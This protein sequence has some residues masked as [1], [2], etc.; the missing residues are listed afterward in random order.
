MKKILFAAS[1]IAIA[2]GMASC[3]DYFLDLNPTD[4]QTEANFYKTPEEFEAAA[5]STYSFYGFGDVSE[6]VNGTKYTSSYYDML[7]V[8]SDILAGINP[9]AQGILAPSTNDTYWSLCYAKIRKCNVVI[10]KGEEYTGTGSINASLAVARFFRAYQ[11][12]WLLQRFGGVPVITKGLTSTS[13]E[14]YAP[15]NSRYEVAK[16]IF[17][18]LDY[19]IQ[20]LPDESAYDG[21]ISKQG[22][23]AFKARTLLFEATWEKYVGTTTDGDGTTSG[24][25]SDKPVGYPVITKGLT[26]TSEELY[27]PRNSRYEVAKQIFDD[28]DYAI[29]Y[30]PDESA[31]DGK[32]SKQG[33]QAF[34][35]RTLLFEATWE[36][37]VGTTTDGDGTTSG[38]G[39]DK[40]V[41]YPDIQSMLTEAA[42]LADAVMSSGKYQLWNAEGTIYEGIAY[43]YLFN[44][45]DENTNPM[46]FTK[47]KNHEFIL[48]IAYNHTSKRIG[49][50]I[51]KATGGDNNNTGAVTIKMVNMFPCVT[52]GLPYFYSKDYKGYN[53]MTDIYTCRDTRFTSCIKIPG[54]TYYWMGANGADKSLYLKANYVTTFDFPSGCS[55]YYPLVQNSGQT[56]FQNRKMCSERKD[57]KDT[58]EGY[59]YPVLR[60]A[61]VYLI[62]AEAKC[63]LGDG[64][65]SDSDLDKSINLL[66]DR[67]GSARISNASVAQ[68]NANYQA[69][70][71]KSGNLTML[72]LIRNERAVE[73]RNENL[74]PTDLLRWGIAEEALNADRSGIVVKNPD[75]ND[76]EFAGFG[77]EVAGKVEKIWDGVAIY[78]YE[79][80]DDGSQALIINSKSQFNMQRKHY[81]YPLPLAQIQLNPALL[82]NPGY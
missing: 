66:H 20:Y 67:G 9:V 63:E 18:D 8:N 13:E 5:N 6:T 65:I 71:G 34:K 50:N 46:G 58:D 41:G 39:S 1:A 48:Q 40:P 2:M 81:L 52:D 24:A 36:K 54:T 16:Q 82:Q 70:T 78:G 28:L 64:R 7:D 60:L 27:A 23:Q 17:D 26:S 53:K 33:A 44:L 22:A 30:L 47:D 62:Y 75:G 43:N 79:T 55:V 80:L 76:T 25:G 32:I 37:Y 12:F 73:L 74:R 42:S 77:Y 68:A 11:Y 49:K 51:T 57:Y 56:G 19:A 4:Q 29:Q 10:E 69:N 72:D 21:K 3:S 31:Y 38:A 15:R 59:N 45:E 14:L 61:E 35:A